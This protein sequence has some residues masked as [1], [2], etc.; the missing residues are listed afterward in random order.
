MLLTMP[1]SFD[2]GSLWHHLWIV[3]I[4]FLVN[5]FILNGII[6]KLDPFFFLVDAIR[7]GSTQ[8]EAEYSI[9]MSVNKRIWK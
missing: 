9:L 6:A 7:K 1:F 8:L 5:Y 4:F 2:S 3:S